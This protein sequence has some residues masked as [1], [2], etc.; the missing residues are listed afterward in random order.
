MI[1]S[2]PLNVRQIDAKRTMSPSMTPTLSAPERILLFILV[3][4]GRLIVLRRRGVP[5]PVDK[6]Q[7]V[8]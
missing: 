4:A 1:S 6:Y 2:S 3:R 8:A 7:A 5:V